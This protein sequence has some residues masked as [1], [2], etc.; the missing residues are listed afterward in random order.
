MKAFE[1]LSAHNSIKLQFA[2]PK[3]VVGLCGC[4]MRTII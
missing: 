2:K 3:S 1:M 4:A